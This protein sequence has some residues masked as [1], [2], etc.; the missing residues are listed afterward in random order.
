MCVCLRERERER[1][2]SCRM[3]HLCGF[4]LLLTPSCY[5]CALCC[6]PLMN[7]VTSKQSQQYGRR[8]LSSFVKGGELESTPL[9]SASKPKPKLIFEK[10]KNRED[11]FKPPAWCVCLFSLVR[12]YRDTLSCLPWSSF[13]L[14]FGSHDS[15]FSFFLMGRN[16]NCLGLR[17]LA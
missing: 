14:H 13:Y 3:F 17:F 12:E 6:F 4:L 16:L 5:Q 15:F 9:S 1:H 10:P 11:P 2:G 7:E 8:T